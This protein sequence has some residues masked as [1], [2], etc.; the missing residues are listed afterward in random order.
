MSTEKLDMSIYGVPADWARR[1]H[2]DAAKYGSMYAS[3]ASTPDAFWAEHGKR[4]DWIKPFTK[5]KNTSFAPGKVSIKWFE[6]GT[7]NV[8]MNCI[9]RHLARRAGQ[10]AIIWEGDDPAESKHITYAQLHDQVCRFANVL[11]SHGVSKG[12]T[13]TIRSAASP[14][15]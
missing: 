5:V 2:A 8:A 14:M 3:S 10:V 15:S 4:I 11:K 13:V 9:D 7:T 12:D 6:D 1:A